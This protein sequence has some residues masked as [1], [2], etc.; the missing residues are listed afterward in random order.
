MSPKPALKREPSAVPASDNTSFP[1]AAGA[2]PSPRRISVSPIQPVP[3]TPKTEPRK[4]ISFQARVPVITGEATYRGLIPVDG[5]ITGQLGANGSALTI[6]QRPRSGPPDHEPELN[7][8]ITF[9]DMLRINGHVAG[10][11]FSYKGTVIVDNSAR[12]DA[13]IDVAVC[14]V[15][16]TVNGDV[17]AQKR[18]EL[19]PAA[20][21]NGNIST[22][23]LSMRP[24]AI[25]TGNCR[26]LKNEDGDK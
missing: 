5:I 20:V 25:F 12:V 2:V 11:I 1:S 14:V 7:G 17:V 21:I 8:E 13:D 23:S 10:K 24:G 15:S 6:K 16:G 26:M 19:G 22:G 4:Q 18:V 9:K 3:N